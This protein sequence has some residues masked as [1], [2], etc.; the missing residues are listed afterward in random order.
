M[1]E[2]KRITKYWTDVYTTEQFNLAKKQCVKWWP[3]IGREDTKI[4]VTSKFCVDILYFN[5][6]SEIWFYIDNSWEVKV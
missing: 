3:K 1:T 4:D 5:D 6:G 2:A